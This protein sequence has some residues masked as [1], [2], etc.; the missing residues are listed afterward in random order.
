[1]FY[2]AYCK[3]LIYNIKKRPDSPPRESAAE[4]RD[5]DI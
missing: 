4:G 1:M 5:L 2:N 3:L